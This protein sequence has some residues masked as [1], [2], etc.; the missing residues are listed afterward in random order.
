MSNLTRTRQGMFKIEDSNSISDIKNSN[1]KVISIKEAL[2]CYKQIEVDDKLLFKISNGQKIYN[3]YLDD[4]VVFTY[5]SKVV[6]IY[7]K[8]DKYYKAYRVF[9]VK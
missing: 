9:N 2:S 4:I 6:A 3:D 7:K 8:C 1:Y 5:K